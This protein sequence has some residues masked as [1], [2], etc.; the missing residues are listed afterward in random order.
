MGSRMKP[1]SQLNLD[2]I[3]MLL[4]MRILDDL[5]HDGE[6][7]GGLEQ[8][9]KL[10]QQSLRI[11]NLLQLTQRGLV[12]TVQKLQSVA[13]TSGSPYRPTPKSQVPDTL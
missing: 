9:D 13:S 11:S 1:D 7:S 6:I 5:R 4:S 3:L 12:E 8:G 2:D 10:Y